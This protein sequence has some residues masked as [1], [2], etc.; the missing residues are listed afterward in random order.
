MTSAAEAEQLTI[1]DPA[2]DARAGG[3]DITGVHIRNRD[4]AIRTTVLFVRDHPGWVIVAVKVRQGPLLRVVSR[5]RASG[6]DKVM[7]IN[8]RGR[9]VQCGGLTSTWDRSAATVQLRLPSGCV[10][11]GNYGAIRSSWTL[12]ESLRRGIDVDSALSKKWISRG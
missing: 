12:I 3:L 2:G 6:P 4:H 5:H 1:T 11:D 9:E 8:R 7:L 10:R